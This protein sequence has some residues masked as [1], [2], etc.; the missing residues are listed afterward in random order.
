MQNLRFIND[1]PDLTKKYKGPLTE[2]LCRLDQ[3]QRIVSTGEVL[4]DHHGLPGVLEP[5]LN[6]W[7]VSA[8]LKKDI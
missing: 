2:I 3:R 1:G 4:W 7:I 5:F 6:P 8:K